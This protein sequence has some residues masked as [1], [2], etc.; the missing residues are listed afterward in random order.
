LGYR[1]KVRVRVSPNLVAQ[2]RRRRPCLGKPAAPA[3]PQRRRSVPS[4]APRSGR[5]AR[6]LGDQA[7][8]SGVLQ[9]ADPL[10]RVR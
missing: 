4:D 9:A 7:G 3:V 10:V 5:Q 2:R 6:R 1:V 8:G